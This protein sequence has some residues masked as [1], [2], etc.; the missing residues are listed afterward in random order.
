LSILEGFVAQLF[1]EWLLELIKIIAKMENRLEGET[2]ARKTSV[3]KIWNRLFSVI[4]TESDYS[5]INV[6]NGTEI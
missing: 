1:V 2:M 5:C 6:K 3:N 4:R